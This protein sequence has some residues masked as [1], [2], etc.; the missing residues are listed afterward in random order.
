LP[1]ARSLGAAPDL[2]S[3]GAFLLGPVLAIVCSVMLILYSRAV[4]CSMI[5]V[6]LTA[7]R[8]NERYGFR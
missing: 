8:N 3:T 1:P 4:S 7:K 2:A 6:Y 5:D